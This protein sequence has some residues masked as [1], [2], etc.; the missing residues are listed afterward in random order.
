MVHLHNIKNVFEEKCWKTL[1]ETSRDRTNNEYLC[2][3]QERVINFDIYMQRKARQTNTNMKKSFDA[4]YFNCEDSHI[5]CVEFKKRE[6]KEF[7]EEAENIKGKFIEGLA[8][9]RAVFETQNLE[10]SNY[11][12]HLFVVFKVLAKQKESIRERLTKR[13]T[14]Y[15]MNTEKGNFLTN[16]SNFKKQIPLCQDTNKLDIRVDYVHNFKEEYKKLFHNESNC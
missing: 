15:S 6:C 1:K 3:S 10:I 13:A 5:Y 9:L 11:N 12:F 4:L 8:E 14:T 2:Q 7:S 16:D